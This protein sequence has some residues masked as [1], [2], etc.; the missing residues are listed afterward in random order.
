LEQLSTWPQLRER[1]EDLLKAGTSVSKIAAQLNTEGLRTVDGKPF[2]EQCI[3]MIMLRQEL[4]STRRRAGRSSIQLGKHEW[5]IGELAK[6]LQVGYGT[7][8]QW[9]VAQRVQAWK[10]DDG[11]WVVIADAVKCR[12]LTA[13]QTR[14]T[15]RRGYQESSSAGARL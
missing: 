3:R 4:H 5:L 14:R 15:Q 13:F 2:T 10:L 7:I 1:I 6:K 8:H 11:R 9:I 12:E